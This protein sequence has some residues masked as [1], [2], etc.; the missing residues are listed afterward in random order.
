MS[1]RSWEAQARTKG[2]KEEG[3]VEQGVVEDGVDQ[4]LAWWKTVKTILWE[5]TVAP[6]GMH[7]EN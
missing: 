3:V 2:G 5:H 4:K 6:H 1:A 7:T